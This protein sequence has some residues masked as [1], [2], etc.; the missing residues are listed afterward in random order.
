[1]FSVGFEGNSALVD[2][3]AKRANGRL[4]PRE[5]AGKGLF[6][7]AVFGAYYDEDERELEEVLAVYN[8]KGEVRL[9]SVDALKRTFGVL[10]SF[11]D[12]NRVMYV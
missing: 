6:K 5:L 4:A 8:S 3:S 2:A 7:A 9:N 12:I 11:D 10:E 1:M